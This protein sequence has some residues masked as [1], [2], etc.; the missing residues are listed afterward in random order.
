MKK[1]T[2]LPLVSMA[3]PLVCLPLAAHASVFGTL[4]NFDVIN[5]TGE[6][7]HGF[8]IELEGLHS[9]DITDTFG[10]LNR[11]FPSGTGF[12]PL[13]AVVRYGAPSITEY[14][15][16]SVF[17]TRITYAATFSPGASG[18]PGSWDFGTPSGSFITP[19]DNCW[20]GGGV[21]YGPGTPCDHF[22]VGT[23]GNA[24]KTTYSW[25]LDPAN[26]GT[27]S[28]A[29]GAVNLPTPVWQVIPNA[30]PAAPPQVI[31]RVNGPDNRDQASW[32]FADA[33]WVKVFTTEVGRGVNLEELIGGNQLIK[34]AKDALPEIEWQLV[35]KDFN[36]PNSG[37][38]E[39]DKPAG[40][41][42]EAVVRRYE[43]F[44]YAGA[45]DAE[46]HEAKVIKDVL[47]G[48][49]DAHPSP[50]DVGTYLGAQNGA[51]NLAAI[52]PVPEPETYAMMLAGL[53]MVF[54]IARR[55]RKAR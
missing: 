6:M 19:G 40:P 55:R 30:N 8:E 31:A 47:L 48:F 27:L 53:G 12:D 14:S 25:L 46:T 38:V 50:D 33:I 5:D 7:A 29:N 44:K 52:A 26:S 16:G 2:W 1:I 21:G 43:F 39:A 13:T 28:G 23:I 36:N 42:A 45:Y 17:G 34:D 22:G 41:N 10:G 37:V 51:V 4:G 49:N 11:G 15:N 20:T 35:Q 24:T 32:E 18:S 9:S 54:G 3:I